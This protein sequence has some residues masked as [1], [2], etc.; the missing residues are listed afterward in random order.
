MPSGSI[1]KPTTGR[2]PSTPPIHSETPKIVRW[3]R[4]P[5]TLMLKRPNR[6]LDLLGGVCVIVPDQKIGFAA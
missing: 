3:R 1:Q 6:I 5:G 2:K 4:V